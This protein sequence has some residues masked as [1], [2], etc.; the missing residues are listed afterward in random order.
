MDEHDQCGM[1]GMKTVTF[2]QS[3]ILRLEFSLK[4]EQREAEKCRVKDTVKTFWANYKDFKI[5]RI[6]L[7]SLYCS[8]G[9]TMVL[10]R[11]VRRM[12]KKLLPQCLKAINLTHHHIREHFTFALIF[13][14]KNKSVFS[15]PSSTI[16]VTEKPCK[17]EWAKCISRQEEDLL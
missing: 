7:V 13:W 6:N 10:C 2:F 3:T 9:R 4:G 11:I 5:F 8:V 14:H 16:L 15:I 12:I 1:A 17:E